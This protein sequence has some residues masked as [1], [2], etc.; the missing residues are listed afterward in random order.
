[1]SRIRL[2]M[3][4]DSLFTAIWVVTAVIFFVEARAA[5]SDET[6]VLPTYSTIIPSSYN[7]QIDGV[8]FQG[9]INGLTASYNTNVTALQESIRASAQLSFR[10]NLMSGF[11]ASI[12]NGGADRT[13][14]ERKTLDRFNS[15]SA[16]SL[17][18][19]NMCPWP[20][21]RRGDTS[22]MRGSI[23]WSMVA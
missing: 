1:M 20:S 16:R 13:G 21:G 19:R 18:L 2:L 5:H 7:L 8:K 23:G 4:V 14:N 9:V 15:Y 17:R 3:T 10:L 6:I 22:A 11:L 12:G